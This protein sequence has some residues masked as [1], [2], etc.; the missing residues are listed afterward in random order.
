MDYFSGYDPLVTKDFIKITNPSNIKTYGWL[1]EEDGIKLLHNNTILSI[2][3]TKYIILHSIN[4]SETFLNSLSSYIKDKDILMEEDFNKNA[5]LTNSIIIDSKLIL[6]DEEEKLKLYQKEVILESNGLY[7][8]SFNIRSI[9]ELDNYLHID[10]YGKNYDN[11]GQE[12]IISPEDITTSYKKIEKIIDSSEVPKNEKIYFRI[13]TN[14][15]G[16]IEI[17]GLNIYK[18][19]KYDNNYSIKHSDGDILV[20]ENKNC[21]PRFYFL[22]NLIASNNQSEIFNNL[23]YKYIHNT[24]NS[25]NYNTSGYVENINYDYRFIK[26]DSNDKIDIIEY[27]NNEVLLKISP[28][29]DSFLVFSDSYYPGWNAYINGTETRI[30]RVNG[31]VKGIFVPAGNSVIKFVYS[32]VKIII[33]FIISILTI[34]SIFATILFLYFKNKKSEN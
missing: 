25:L 15:N 7:F 6:P 11:A 3:N 32:P 19:K 17:S 16:G 5:E 13:F 33:P 20:L 23:W 12:F 29:N 26:Q 4:D 8:I 31:I 21:L 28:K 10:F 34:I 30:Y 9:K 1:S 2:L 18:I 22:E 24:D 14:S 27:K